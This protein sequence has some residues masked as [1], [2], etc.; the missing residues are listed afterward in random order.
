[1]TYP[2]STLPVN[3]IDGPSATDVS[4]PAW[5]LTAAEVNATN[6]AI[7]DIVTELGTDPS[8][9]E[10]TVTAR[11][12]ALDS[13]VAAKA[14][15]SATTAALAA[16]AALAGATYTGA[17]DFTG[18][19]VTGISGGGGATVTLDADGTLVVD[20]TAVELAT[21]G[22]LAS[23]LADKA[24]AAATT[25]ALAGKAASVHTHAQSDVTGLSASLAAKSDTGHAHSAADV[26][27][28]TLPLARGGTGGTD[29]ATA[30]TALGLGSA[31]VVNAG[32]ASGEVPVLGAGGVLPMARLAT[33]TPDGS[34]FVRDDG[35]LA[36]PA[37][38]SGWAGFK[39]RS[40]RWRPMFVGANNQHTLVKDQ[41]I[42]IGLLLAPQT[43]TGIGVSVGTA[44]T[45]SAAIRLGIRAQT[46]D[47]YPGAPVLDV[48]LPA[49]STGKKTTTISY[50]HPGGVLW[51]CWVAQGWTTTAPRVYACR[52]NA[53][54]SGS[55]GGG[56]PTFGP[57]D[58]DSGMT[59]LIETLRPQAAMS[60]GVSGA[61]PATVVNDQGWNNS[62]DYF[63]HIY[64]K[65]A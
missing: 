52:S 43:F 42:V 10:A 4:D 49:T 60:S 37:S 29:A 26:T 34:K 22:Q 53:E 19:T 36:V 64:L 12:S 7:N 17:H 13:T 25:S 38:G 62:P 32:T 41:E 27:T 31:A 14:D 1:M 59:T 18:A 28:G 47:S 55:S 16:K 45:E 8:G 30:R 44:G 51:L 46:A 40:G 24:D 3:A 6:V 39:I 57:V 15:A 65:G 56:I 61:L 33:G 11:L 9:A 21:D 58:Y 54:S 63:P 48:V 20:G 35:A 23:G 5:V 50:T 2:P